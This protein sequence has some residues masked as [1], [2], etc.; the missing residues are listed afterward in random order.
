[1][2]LICFVLA[3]RH[4]GT[5][6]TGVYFA[7]APFVGA[8]VAMAGLSEP[9]SAPFLAATAL[10]GVGLWL[11]LTKRYEHEH[12]HEPMEHDHMHVHD[13]HHRHEHAPTGPPGEP[14]SHPDRH[15]ALRHPHPHY[16]DL[17]HRHSH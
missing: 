5:A 6:R 10:M 11:H 4:L 8:A 15:E 14:R 13:E 12:V 2:S 17:H 3:V 1:V 16:P 7:L 9:L